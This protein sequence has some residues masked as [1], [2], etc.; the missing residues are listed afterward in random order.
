MSSQ[1]GGSVIRAGSR[2]SALVGDL[3]YW[4]GASEYDAN[5]K[6]RKRYKEGFLVQS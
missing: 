4:N 2:V 5:G 3:G 6:K 1:G